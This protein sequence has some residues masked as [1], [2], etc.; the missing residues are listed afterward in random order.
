MLAPNLLIIDDDPTIRQLLELKAKHYGFHPITAS[1]AREGLEL[2]NELLDVIL[3][4][5]HMPD[6]DGFETL[7]IL[8]KKGNQIPVLIL[9]GEHEATFAMKAVK[10][11]AMDY[12]CKPFDLDELFT[13]LRNAKKISSI[14]KENTEL[15]ETIAPSSSTPNLIAHSPA[16]KIVMQRAKKVAAL[17]STILLTGESG[18]GKGVFARFI[19]ANSER[20]DKPFITVSCPALPR[21]LLESELFGH[22]KGAFTGALKKRIGKIEAAQG[23]TLFLDEIGDLP[24]D[25]Q[26]KLLNVLQDQE[27]YRVGGEKVH[28]SNVRIIAATNINFEKKIRDREFREDLYYRLSVIPIELPPLRERQEEIIPLATFFTAR[29]SENRK[30]KKIEISPN[31]QKALKTYH[32][33]GNVRQ[34]ENILE[35]ACAFCENN[36]I[37]IHDLAGS[38]TSQN[39]DHPSIK[40]LAGHTLAKIETEAI[41]QTLHLCNGNKAESARQLGITEKSIYNKI[42]RLEIKLP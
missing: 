28:T 20:A 21:E 38:I 6:I 13:K 15:R 11:G 37:Q 16:T 8:N 30:I 24:I 31:A 23:G 34:L 9:S 40:G 19:H 14:Q 25:L 17:D 10:L 41:L 18:T 2:V 1:G 39:N 35:R 7:K 4:D 36:T 3:L 32:W 12:I 5:I 26:P 42:K 27:F 22:E 29:I 33:P